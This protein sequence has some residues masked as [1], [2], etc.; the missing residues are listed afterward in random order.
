MEARDGSRFNRK[1]KFERRYYLILNGEKLMKLV[2][3]KNLVILWLIFLPI[4]FITSI[5]ISIFM[6]LIFMG[7]W[8]I[9]LSFVGFWTKNV[10][11]VWS[12][13]SGGIEMKRNPFM[14]WYG[15][16]TWLIIGLA[17]LFFG[18]FRLLT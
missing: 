17:T 9:A 12:V 5:F 6:I 3:Y 2:T 10:A 15:L 16:F 13:H 14:F 1:G 8:L 11:G 4:A 7:L 18:I